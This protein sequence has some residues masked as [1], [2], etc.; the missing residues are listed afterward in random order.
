MCPVVP[1]FEAANLWCNQLTSVLFLAP[2]Y[3]RCN[4]DSSNAKLGRGALTP[5]VCYKWGTRPKFAFTPASVAGE[6]PQCF[7]FSGKQAPEM[8]NYSLFF[9]FLG[10]PDSGFSFLDVAWPPSPDPPP[11]DRLPAYM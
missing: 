2:C 9:F 11:G 7:P 6:Q 3:I 8:R 10:S 4:T 1:A 5:R